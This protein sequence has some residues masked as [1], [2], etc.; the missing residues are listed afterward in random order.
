[1]KLTFEVFLIAWLMMINVRGLRESILMLTPVF[2]AF[3]LT[4]ILLIGAGIF[5]HLP[6]AL[7]VAANANDA[8]HS[9]LTTLGPLPRSPASPSP[10]PGPRARTST[11]GSGASCSAAPGISPTAASTTGWP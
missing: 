5:L 6:Q 3:L 2:I 11:T 9:G 10:C 7:T 4:H 8:Y 1:L